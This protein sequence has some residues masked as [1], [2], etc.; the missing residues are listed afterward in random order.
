MNVCYELVTGIGILLIVSRKK[1][2]NTKSQSDDEEAI[3]F[4]NVFGVLGYPTWPFSHMDPI[5]ED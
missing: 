4:K 3:P 1:A 2:T 5:F